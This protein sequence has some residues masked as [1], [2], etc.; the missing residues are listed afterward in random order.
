MHAC[1]LAVQMIMHQ[2][3]CLMQETRT[4]DNI[5]VDIVH[6]SGK[7]VYPQFERRSD[8]QGLIELLELRLPVKQPPDPVEHQTGKS[9]QQGIDH[10]VL[11]LNPAGQAFAK[12]GQI[13]I[14]AVQ[15]RLLILGLVLVVESHHQLGDFRHPRIHIFRNR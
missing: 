12:L 9:A 2:K 6:T 8:A 1:Q 15:W 4:Q 11:H 10:P 13:P 3:S 7:A 5:E 14:Q